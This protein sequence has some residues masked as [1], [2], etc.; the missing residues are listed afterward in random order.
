MKKDKPSIEVNNPYEYNGEVL[1]TTHFSP[2]PKSLQSTD[3]ESVTNKKK[4]F[5]GSYGC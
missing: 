4:L 2:Q 5:I 3:N 1:K